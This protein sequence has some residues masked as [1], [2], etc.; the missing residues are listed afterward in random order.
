MS[1]LFVPGRPGAL[2]N[3]TPHVGCVHAVTQEYRSNVPHA[4][5]LMHA[6]HIRPGHLRCTHVACLQVPHP[7]LMRP[8]SLSGLA[9]SAPIIESHRVSIPQ[10]HPASPPE[11]F[12][13]V[14]ASVEMLRA[15]T[16]APDADAPGGPADAGPTPRTVSM[17][18]ILSAL[19]SSGAG[20]AGGVDGTRGSAHPAASRPPHGSRVDPALGAVNISAA[21]RRADP[22]ARRAWA[23][24]A[25]LPPPH[26]CVVSDVRQHA[27]RDALRVAG[28]GGGD[29][30][31]SVPM[32]ATDGPQSGGAAALRRWRGQQGGSH[33]AV[34]F[35]VLRGECTVGVDGAEGAL[36]SVIPGGRANGTVPRSVPGMHSV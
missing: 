18:E 22:T 34:R 19:Q 14:A 23:E 24:A 27:A 9:P 2:H 10:L 5:V 26:E 31:V 13:A 3:I 6:L 30:G 35:A 32:H 11:V 16:A 1:V 20:A 33:C 8:H 25:R 36:R 7:L 17:P 15:G 4:F 21:L 28:P 12:Q 29:G